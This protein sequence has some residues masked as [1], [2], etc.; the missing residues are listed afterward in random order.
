MYIR[1]SNRLLTAWS[2]IYG[3][4]VAPNTST[5]SLLFPTPCICTRNSVLIRLAASLSLSPLALQRESNSSMKIIAGLFSRA[6]ANRLLTIFSDSPIH[7]DTR[8]EEETE[9][10]VESASVATA[11]ARYDFPVPGGPYNS[12][13]FHALRLPVKNCGNFTGRITASFSASFAPSNPATSSHFIFGFSLRMALS[14]FP[15]SFAVSAS[16]AS[17]ALSFAVPGLPAP[18]P[19][20]ASATGAAPDFCWST[21]ARTCSALSR[22]S[23]NFF[24]IAS[25]A[26]GFF[27]YFKC[28]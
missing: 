19:A 4:L 27:S 22:Y 9:K 25:F 3:I 11:F 10:N 5:L 15:R 28:V 12:S 14:R 8:V 26:L 23:V 1:L 21:I 16:S 2:S 13:A 17:F 24:V 18:A 6:I 20:G 7:L